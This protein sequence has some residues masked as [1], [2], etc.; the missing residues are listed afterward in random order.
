MRVL[1]QVLEPIG[2]VQGNL[3]VYSEMF[4]NRGVRANEGEEVVGSGGGMYVPV[5]MRNLDSECN[6]EQ[7][8]Q[9]V[10]LWDGAEP[11]GSKEL[12]QA[13]KPTSGTAQQSTSQ[14]ECLCCWQTGR[15]W[16]TTCV[17]R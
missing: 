4:D 15:R 3:A 10:K 2:E 17:C 1:Q 13:M 14:L 7:K 9:W 12:G 8:A 6:Q 11:E 16:C 5:V